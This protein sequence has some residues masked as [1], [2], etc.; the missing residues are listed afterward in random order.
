MRLINRALLYVLSLVILLLTT[1]CASVSY[2][3]VTF[4]VL[5]PADYTL[6]TWTD[7][8]M[9]VDNVVNGLCIDSTLSPN[10][11][12]LMDIASYGQGV[13][14]ERLVA[15]VSAY[16]DKSG[17]VAAHECSRLRSS[18][19]I[20]KGILKYGEE[21]WQ[22]IIAKRPLSNHDVDSILM[23][24]Q[25]SV[26]L[27]LDSVVSESYITSIQ[28][29]NHDGETQICAFIEMATT[30]HFT[31]VT[32]LHQ[33]IPLETRKDTL[34]FESCG[35]NYYEVGTNF[36]PFRD[37]YIEQCSYIAKLYASS[38]IPTWDRVQ[39]AVYVTNNNLMLSAATWLDANNWDEAKALWTNVWVDADEPNKLRAA[40]N[41]ALAA[42]REDDAVQAALWC[43]R[44]LDTFEAMPAKQ[45]D[46]LKREKQKADDMFA[47][48]IRRQHDKEVLDKQMR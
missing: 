1:R 17:Y 15:N 44:A 37:R 28:E 21:G 3:S 42:E 19:E 11:K 18:S 29:A 38:L 35:A 16:I 41:L 7:T 10:D 46:K 4:D 27:S 24:R 13:I 45:Q 47:Y 8:I 33:R 31:L 39:R 40:L 5:Q 34:R 36:P 30:T 48:F 32:P 22:R 2:K 12:R 14:P 26:I 20:I 6:P 25:H 43:S 9:V 23:G